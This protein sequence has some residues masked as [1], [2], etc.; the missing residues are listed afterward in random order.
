MK[1]VVN[2]P[3]CVSRSGAVWK[4]LGYPVKVG[5]EGVEVMRRASSPRVACARKLRWKA[6]FAAV[7]INV[8]AANGAWAAQ[9][10]AL[11]V[12]VSKYDKVPSLANPAKDAKLVQATLQKLGFQVKVLTDPNR[13]QLIEGLGEFEE[14]AKGSEAAVIYY[15]GHGA[16]I[17]GVNYL[18]PKDALSTNKSALTGTSVESARLGQSMM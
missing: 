12:G 4:F 9:R 15:A 17:D 3:T 14:A 13:A 18:L 11:I 16:M 2:S 6:V 1:C 8:V 5:V 7:V 10:V